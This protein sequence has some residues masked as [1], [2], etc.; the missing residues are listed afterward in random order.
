M[1]F[2]ISFASFLN[3]DFVEG[4]GGM[5][6]DRRMETN[7]QIKGQVIKHKFNWG[8]SVPPKSSPILISLC[9]DPL[10]FRETSL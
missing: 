6:Q 5:C 8:K 1:S 7:Q 2:D 10:D 3:L 9:R 4:H